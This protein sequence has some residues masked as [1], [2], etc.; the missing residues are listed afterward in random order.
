MRILILGGTGEAR[1]L[2]SALVLRGH[3]VTTSLAGRTREP[4][5]PVG[6]VRTGGFGGPTGL[7]R[8]L[9]DEAVELLIDATHPFAATISM[10]AMVAAAETGVRRIAFYR[11]LW[12]PERGDRWQRVADLPAATAVLPSGAVALLALGR[13]HIAPFASRPDVRF[14]VRAIEPFDLP[15]AGTL[16]LQR[17]S[18]DRAS[19]TDLLQRHGITHVV[20]RNSGGAG[21]YAKIAAARALGLPVAMIDRPPPPPPPVHAT[22]DALLAAI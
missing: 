5:P 18:R 19:E 17:P 21:A 9:A 3:H 8:H 16:L 7:A 13:Q 10:N 4:V 14:V 22:I 11:P 15:F 2:A 6:H 1:D 12:Q 20:S